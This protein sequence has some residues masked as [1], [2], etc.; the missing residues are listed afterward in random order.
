MKKGLSLLFL[1]ERFQ[2]FLLIQ[3]GINKKE[4]PQNILSIHKI[5]SKVINPF[6]LIF[7]TT[8]VDLLQKNKLPYIFFS[9]LHIMRFVREPLFSMVK[10]N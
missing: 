1:T 6:C 8:L 4:S 3:F 2:D 10:E 9:Q 5:G 7:V